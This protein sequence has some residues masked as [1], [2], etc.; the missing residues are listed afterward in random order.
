MSKRLRTCLEFLPLGL[1]DLRANC[2]LAEGDEQTF[3]TALKAARTDGT[4][5]RD[6]NR[7]WLR[8]ACSIR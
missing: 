2:V 7:E 1:D 4:I 8:L 6:R 5:V 3:E